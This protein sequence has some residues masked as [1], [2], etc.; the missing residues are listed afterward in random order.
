MASIEIANVTKQWGTVVG[1]DKL[2]LKIDEGE[3]LVLLGPS[4]CGKTTTMRIVAG[5][6]NPTS[7]E[8]IFDGQNVTSMDTRDRNVAMVF[9]NYSL[10]P[11]M[12]V[13][14][15][16]RFPLRARKVAREEHESLVRKAATMVDLTDYLDRKPGSLSGGQRQRVALARAI[17]RSPTAFLMDEPLSNLDAR[18][19]I[20]MRA[21][22]KHLHEELKTTTIYVTHDQLEAMTLADRIVVMNKGS[23]EQ[24]G[25]PKEIYENPKSAFVASF[26]GSP[27]MNLINAD[28]I[29][30]QV[31]GPGVALKMGVEKD[32][33]A[34]ILGARAEDL[35]PSEPEAA[36]LTG[37][38]NT[39]E[40]I[41]DA[42][43]VTVDLGEAKLVAKLD[44]DVTY[45]S[46]DTIGLNI[47][48]RFFVFDRE[49]GV[50]T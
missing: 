11:Q 5:L 47:G 30:G 21:L 13:Y 38:V 49:T 15:N 10:Y 1:I 22:I 36:E 44:K 40:L 8:I 4:G 27:S 24:I 26:I 29:N 34:I 46:G 6:E 31:S 19:R 42:T 16:I 37:I 9:Q 23:V 32:H 28:H 17:V 35:I 25:S 45:Q 12:T 41:G 39:V 20:A 18:L 14:E 3:F 43:L 2:T 7:G 50:R 33:G 48:T